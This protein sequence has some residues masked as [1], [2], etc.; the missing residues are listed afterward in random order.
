M[1]SLSFTKFRQIVDVLQLSGIPIIQ[2]PFIE[3]IIR[4]RS[5]IDV[6]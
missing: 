5:R 3:E 2:I 1:S 4:L 6:L